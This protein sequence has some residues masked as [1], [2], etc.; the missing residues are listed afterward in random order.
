VNP[1]RHLGAWLALLMAFVLLGLYAWTSH[2][3]KVDQFVLW[4]AAVGQVCFVLLW[5]TQRWWTTTVGVALIAKSAALA[6]LLVASVWAMYMGPLPLWMARTLVGLIAVTIVGQL[7][8][9]AA[10]ILSAR[11]ES[12]SVS[13]LDN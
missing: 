4:V 8:A 5:A 13:G 7:V 2:S 6:A 12:R 9:L 3:Q 11:R 1:A 10:E